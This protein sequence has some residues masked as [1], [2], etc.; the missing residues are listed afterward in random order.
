MNTVFNLPTVVP[1]LYSPLAK[2]ISGEIDCSYD[3]L[4]KYSTDNSIYTIRPQAVVYPKNASDIKHVL[5]FAREYNMPVAVRGNG[6]A[7]SG[8]S[9][10]EG[11]IIDTARH[12]NYVNQINIMENTVTVGAGVS[13][14]ELREKLH[15]WNVDIPILT[16][17]DEDGTIGGLIATKSATPTSFC[18]GTIREWVESLNVVVDTGEEHR[19]ADGITPSGRL[20]GI[21]QALF[22]ILSNGGP[23]LRA[24][25]PTEHD[26]ATGYSVWNT[27][28]GPRQLLDELVGS[29]GTLGIITSVTLRLSPYKPHAIT[30]YIPITNLSMI[31]SIVEIAKRHRAEHIFLYDETLSLLSSKFHPGLLPEL[32]NMPYILSVTHFDTDKEK[33]HDK[34]KI[35]TKAIPVEK[36]LCVQ[37]ED[38]DLI[39]KISKKSFLFSIINSYTQG[40]QIPSSIADGIIVSVHNYSEI[41]KEFDDYLS[42]TGLLYLVTGNAGSGH[43]SIITTFDYKSPD[44]EK[45]LDDYAKNIFTI[46]KKYKGGISAI[47]GDGLARTLYLPYIYNQQTLDIFKQIKNAWDSRG[48]L[49]PGKKIS[50]TVNYLRDHL[51]R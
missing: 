28:I 14:K 15:S 12:I 26:D 51:I 8:G 43:I 6:T 18:H 33:L 34:V 47:N 17:Q 13:I 2:I 22:P 21:Y 44:Y 16:S 39:E 42:S 41:L 40:S 11:I 35:F 3:V 37:S 30:T 46:V 32:V 31:N 19:I 25:K 10:C 7:C 9:L 24:S 23:M 1:P 45:K 38:L 5:S 27:S 50:V 20:L 29:E 48:T 4:T 49:N 36:N